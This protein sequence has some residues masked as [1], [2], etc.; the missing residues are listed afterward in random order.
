[1]LIYLSVNSAFV[2]VAS[3]DFGGFG[4]CL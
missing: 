4:G 3:L 1:M 2:S